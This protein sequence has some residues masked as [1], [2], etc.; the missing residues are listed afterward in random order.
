MWADILGITPNPIESQIS[1][2]NALKTAQAE[3]EKLFSPVNCQVSG[4]V[5]I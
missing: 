5:L 1:I 4:L 2:A 3:E